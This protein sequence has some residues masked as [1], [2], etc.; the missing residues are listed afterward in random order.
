M[1]PAWTKHLISGLHV[2]PIQPGDD[3]IPG[4]EFIAAPGHTAGCIALA[5]RQDEEVAIIAA[6]AIPWAEVARLERSA[7]VFWDL[8][9]RRRR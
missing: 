9:H 4:V 5:I 1:T 8:E 3:V 6:D 2:T 7:L